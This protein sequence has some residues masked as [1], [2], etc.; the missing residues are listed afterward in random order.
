MRSQRKMITTSGIL[1]FKESV[2]ALKL[3][4]IALAVIGLVGLNFSGRH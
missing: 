3:I 4:S 1:W 2:N